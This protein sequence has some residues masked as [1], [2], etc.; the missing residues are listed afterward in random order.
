M[1]HLLIGYGN[2]LRNDDGAGQRVA[3]MVAEWELANVRS[4]ACV[5]LTPELA[6]EIALATTVIFVDA[7]AVEAESPATVEVQPLIL[8][9]E[10]RDQP[11]KWGHHGDPRSLLCLTYQLYHASP[12][13]YWVLIP[14]INFEVGDE[15]SPTTEAAI[16]VTLERIKQILGQVGEGLE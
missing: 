16:Q 9:P 15:L 13:A 6:A 14:G 11:V 5:Q 1:T 8:E 12:T 7:V 2:T 3:E 4:H 10:Q